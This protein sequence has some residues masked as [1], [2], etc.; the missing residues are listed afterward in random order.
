ME[1]AIAM[2]NTPGTPGS[3]LVDPV[4]WLAEAIRGSAG[5]RGQGAQAQ[6]PQRQGPWVQGPRL[7]AE[8][9]R[10]L[11]RE[12]WSELLNHD[13]NVFP[14]Q[15]EKLGVRFYLQEERR[16]HRLS[17]LVWDGTQWRSIGSLSLPAS[18]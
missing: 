10:R 1:L 15:T 14:V 11:A 6:S 17:G 3:R 5:P 18:D 9:A 7:S 2:V 4:A 8:S 16:G 13:P 12:C